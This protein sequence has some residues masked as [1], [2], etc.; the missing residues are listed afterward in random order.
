VT[1][2]NTSLAVDISPPVDPPQAVDAQSASANSAQTLEL[3][4]AQ[5]FQQPM[6]VDFG[7]GIGEFAPTS[8]LDQTSA[9][10][11]QAAGSGDDAPAA[12]G[13]PVAQAQAIAQETAP[14][15]A[16]L[17]VPMVEPAPAGLVAALPSLNPAPPSL[18]TQKTAGRRGSALAFDSSKRSNNTGPA[19][20]QRAVLTKAPPARATA[21][22]SQVAQSLVPSSR[23]GRPPSPSALSR[24]RN[25]N[26]EVQQAVYRT[27]R[28]GVANTVGLAVGLGTAAELGP[29]AG[30]IAGGRTAA[31]VGSGIDFVAELTKAR[32]GLLP[33]TDTQ[34]SFGGL[35]ASLLRLEPSSPRKVSD[36]IAGTVKDGVDGAITTA[37]L[38]ATRR[39][40]VPSADSPISFT[41]LGP[42]EKGFVAAGTSTLGAVAQGLADA[43][44]QRARAVLDPTTT[45]PA[46][47]DRL[48]KQSNRT[49][50]LAFSRAP[51][52]FAS[53]F[54]GVAAAS[55]NKALDVAN[56]V[57]N[58][59]VTGLA[60]ATLD[61][62]AAG[63][64]D[65]LQLSAEQE[66]AALAGALLRAAFNAA[67]R[68]PASLEETYP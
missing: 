46:D 7:A 5:Q 62:V 35:L 44:L 30:V 21:P 51:A 41:P 49:A 28:D 10:V 24:A 9:A 61:N 58:G 2:L 13:R 63:Q 45:T 54:L 4:V 56:Q 43:G 12:E 38:L 20:Q 50:S 60:Q 59:F 55:N 15:Y 52:L 68:L 37:A 22:A 11:E 36:A 53:A 23:P 27:A 39:A 29:I 48:T 65:P 57:V 8:L 31:L 64:S 42:L 16:A 25:D 6:S 26:V 17:Q 14:S 33:Q 18:N 40:Q 19:P 32:G 3:D 67:Q 34:Q 1:T 47:A 66:A